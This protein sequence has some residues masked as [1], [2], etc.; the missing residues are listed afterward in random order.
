MQVSEPLFPEYE[1][2]VE[3]FLRAGGHTPSVIRSP[4]GLLNRYKS[5]FAGSANYGTG[6]RIEEAEQDFVSV[7][8]TTIAGH[9]FE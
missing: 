3:S 4:P 2:A 5:A 9:D 8:G 7:R 6:V 1:A